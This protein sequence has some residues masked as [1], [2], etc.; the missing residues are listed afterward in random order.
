M[1]KGFA[2]VKDSPW[3]R[4]RRGEGFAVAK[5]STWRRFRAGSLGALGESVVVC[6]A[7][8]RLF[9][10]LRRGSPSVRASSCSAFFGRLLRMGRGC[11]LG[12]A[13]LDRVLRVLCV[14]GLPL[15]R[16]V[17]R[18]LFPLQVGR[19]AWLAGSGYATL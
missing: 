6:C 16:R 13:L 12:G 1:V 8:V 17:F 4:I 5:V 7:L 18:K 10:G 11:P 15:L 19:R 3:R 14:G 2:V 9:P